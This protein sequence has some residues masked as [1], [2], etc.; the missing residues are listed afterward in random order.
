MS[1]ESDIQALLRSPQV[2]EINFR[3]RGI[4]VTGTGFAGLAN[5]FSENPIPERIQVFPNSDRVPPQ[6]GAEYFFAE[7]RIDLGFDS[8]S[9]PIAQGV[10]VHECT[11]ALNDFRGILTNTRSNESSAYIAQAWFWLAAGMPDD[12]IDR[13]LRRNGEVIRTI[14]FDLRYQAQTTGGI[15]AVSDDQINSARGFVRDTGIYGS[16]ARRYDGLR[17]HR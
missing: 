15:V 9:D 16:H 12:E 11:H 4:R 10:I 14:A 13:R 3:L 1:L 5:H 17:G 7:D 6:F 8:L 2:R